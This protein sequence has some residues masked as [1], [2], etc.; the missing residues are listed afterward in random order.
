MKK[1]LIISPYYDDVNHWMVSTIK[2][3]ENLSKIS[4]VVIFTGGNKTEIK[5]KKNLK[6]YKFKDIFIKDPA[7]YGIIPFQYSKLNKVLKIENPDHVI[8]NKHMFHTALCSIFLK[9]KKIPFTISTDT[10]PGYVWWSENRLVNFVLYLYSRTIGNLALKLSD[11]VILF[12]KGLVD[13]A[14]HLK[15]N[16]KV[17][18]NGVDLKKL[19]NITLKNSKK[20][21]IGYVGRL[22]SV[23]RYKDIIEVSRR[24]S[25]DVEFHFVGENKKYKSNGNI[26]F[27]GY[28]KNVYDYMSKFDIFVISSKSEGLP[29]ALMEAMSLGIAPVVTNVGGNVTLVKNKKN[30]LTYPVGNID[31]LESAI[32]Y[33]INNPDK[34][35]LYGENSKKIIIDKYDWSDIS[36]K[37]I[38]YLA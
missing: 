6:I 38:K 28:K 24:F 25:K 13:T 21:I 34:R 35:R 15:L 36:K 7:N 26:K 4:N 19:E 18:P 3:A 27:I 16:Y 29:N 23:K 32:R 1:I 22:E 5:K 14:K 12:H 11:K 30:G 17:I 37:I 31:R 8:I 10:F 33:L 20:I 9:F 2:Y